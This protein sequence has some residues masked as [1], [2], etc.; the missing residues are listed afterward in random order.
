MT[1]DAEYRH[2]PPHRGRDGRTDPWSNAGGGRTRCARVRGTWRHYEKS[3]P[4][5]RSFR[6]ST[7]ISQDANL[8]EERGRGVMRKEPFEEVT[9]CGIDRYFTTKRFGASLTVRDW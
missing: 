4:R 8:I 1:M 2:Y 7:T 5:N 3:G 9:H 6:Q